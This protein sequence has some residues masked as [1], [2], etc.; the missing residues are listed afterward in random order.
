LE[1]ELDYELRI[2]GADASMRD[3]TV[4][5]LNLRAILK[6]DI[7]NGTSTI[8]IG[9]SGY[10]WNEEH[11]KCQEKLI[12]LLRCVESD[13]LSK[14]VTV[15]ARMLHLKSRLTRLVEKVPKVN[16]LSSIFAQMLQKLQVALDKNFPAPKRTGSKPTSTIINREREVE[17]DRLLGAEGG[18]MLR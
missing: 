17:E 6:T 11:H 4:K 15:E 18:M 13:S 14:D 16:K 7:R 5:Q 9:R 10:T 12:K 2:R 1:D 8:E 3:V